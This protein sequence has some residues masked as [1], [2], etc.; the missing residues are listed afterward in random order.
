MMM[1]EQQVK[2]WA[3]EKAT[4][5]EFV[6]LCSCFGNTTM[7]TINGMTYKEICDNWKD[8]TSC[9]TINA[10]RRLDCNVTAIDI[11]EQALAYGKSVGLYD[12]AIHCNLNSRDTEAFA[13]T[14]QVRYAILSYTE[15]IIQNTLKSITH[16]L[17]H[18]PSR[19]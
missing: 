2:E 14:I 1:L 6:D 19:Q 5:I 13:Q 4:Q 8:E 7:A 15:H 3:S 11:S 10:P 17:T 18:S 12:T 16:S 9:M